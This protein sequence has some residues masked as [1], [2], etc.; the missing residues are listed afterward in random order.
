MLNPE[1]GIA[2]TYSDLGYLGLISA[3]WLDSSIR[4]GAPRHRILYCFCFS[5]TNAHVRLPVSLSA[6]K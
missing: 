5:G 6:V 2:L 4:F 1:Y 3:V